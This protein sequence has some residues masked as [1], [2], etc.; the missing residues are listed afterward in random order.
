MSAED[1]RDY[2]LAI[3][4]SDNERLRQE[5]LEL[6]RLQLGKDAS[7][8]LDSIGHLARELRPG[9]GKWA[10]AQDHVAHIA[11]SLVQVTSSLNNLSAASTSVQFSIERRLE[12][13]LRAL[14]R[15]AAALER[16]APEVPPEEGELDD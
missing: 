4:Q 12:G 13:Q 3:L 5:N 10:A 11:G 16:I 14:E 9:A 1:D 6:Q 2:T 15:I 7:L 8:H